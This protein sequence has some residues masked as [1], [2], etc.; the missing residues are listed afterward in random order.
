M[1]TQESSKNTLFEISCS[2]ILHMNISKAKK[3]EMLE[4]ILFAEDELNDIMAILD[5]IEVYEVYIPIEEK[6]HANS[7]YRLR[8]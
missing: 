7:L 5:L 6:I 2:R 3:I 8:I 1:K 4:D